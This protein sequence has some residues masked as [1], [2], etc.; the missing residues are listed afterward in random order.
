MRPTT[1]PPS[2]PPATP[3]PFSV[4]EEFVSVIAHE[5]KTPI[6]IV[7]GAADAAL[8]GD[9]DDAPQELRQLLEMIRR[10]ADLADLLLRRLTIA[11]DIEAGTVALD[12]ADVDVGRLVEESV[13]DLQQVVLGGHDVRVTVA[14]S[15]M[16]RADATA[17]R[18][19]VFNLLSNAAK[20][21]GPDAPIEITVDVDGRTLDVV[22]RNHGSGVTPGD[23][24]L[25]FE[26]YWQREDDA[27][28]VG[29]GLFISRGLARAHGG[30]ITV[31]PA[32]D[33]GSEFRLSLPLEPVVVDRAQP[34]PA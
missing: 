15:P 19:I 17:A 33:E 28:G 11:R 7:Q 12:L 23:S 30:D 3:A 21:S 10:N 29:L 9:L 4:L 24:D 26:K 34:Q 2:D 1:T 16:V 25:I 5:L 20:Y 22:V 27:P 13:T 14:A 32:T 31:Q 6:A 8:D 18:E